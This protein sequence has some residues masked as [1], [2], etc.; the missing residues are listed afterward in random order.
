MANRP[1]VSEGV[2]V[3]FVS[4]G[5]YAFIMEFKEALINKYPKKCRSD[6]W[7]QVS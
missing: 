3:T 6:S 4:W 5:A 2:A 7:E 1:G